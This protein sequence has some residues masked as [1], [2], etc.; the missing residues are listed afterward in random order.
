M[1]SAFSYVAI[2]TLCLA[3]VACGS[4]E[5]DYSDNHSD[6]HGDYPRQLGRQVLAVGEAIRH[7]QMPDAMETI[8]E[9]GTDSRHYVMVRGWLA[10][11]LQGVES[12]LGASQPGERPELEARAEFLKRAI[13]A[14]D[15]E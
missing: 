6:D 2:M 14:I 12:I 9:L 3:A 5:P 15:L 13:R 8:V 11:E 4:A 1:K 10:L 7:P